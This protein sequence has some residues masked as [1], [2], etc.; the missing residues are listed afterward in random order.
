MS[1]YLLRSSSNEYQAD[2]CYHLH[3]FFRPGC[4]SLVKDNHKQD[5]FSPITDIVYKGYHIMFLESFAVFLQSMRHLV[6][7]DNDMVYQIFK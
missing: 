5:M 2:I 7:V 3:N 6:H 1:E 4:I